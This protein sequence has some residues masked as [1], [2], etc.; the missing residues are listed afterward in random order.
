MVSIIFLRKI[1]KQNE[2]FLHFLCELWHNVKMKYLK[3]EIDGITQKKN[4][5]K[6]LRENNFSEHYISALRNNLDNILIN[7]KPTNVRG[8][9]KNG[10]VLEIAKNPYKATEIELI[11][12]P[13]NI[14][15]ED[16]DYLVINKPPL[17]ATTPTRSHYT[18]NLS[19]MI[20]AYMKKK[21][22]NFTLRI[23]NRLDKDASGLILVAK[24]AIAYQKTVNIKKEYYA[25]CHGILKDVK[26]VDTPILT[27]QENGINIMKRVCDERGQ[28]AKTT[29]TPIKTLKD[30]TLVKAEIEKGRTHQIRLHSSSIGHALIG[31][32]IY[33]IYDEFSHTYLFLKKISFENTKSCKKYAFDLEL[34]SEFLDLIKHK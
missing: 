22:D 11:E 8:T 4:I 29:L 18:D 21:D 23:M 27:L 33:G 28:N 30:K 10:D 34:P 20:C 31:D 24:D 1:V 17:L 6:F 15:Y 5:Y 7:G 16:D 25:I 2:K 14:V 3:I 19:G 13:L 9:L 32:K 12:K 26:V